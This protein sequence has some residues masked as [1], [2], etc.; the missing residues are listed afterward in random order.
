M[1]QLEQ[2]PSRDGLA[3]WS[4][5]PACGRIELPIR[6]IHLWVEDHGQS[7][8]TFICPS[9]DGLVRK[10][11]DAG[12]VGLLLASSPPLER[13]DL[14]DFKQELDRDDW[15]HRFERRFGS[16]LRVT[17]ITSNRRSEH[18]WLR[19]MNFLKQVGQRH[20]LLSS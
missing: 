1:G 15:F 9:C 10:H 11:A 12:T 2:T 6:N 7:S 17:R 16:A 3:I 8:Y 4:H 18:R 14:H 13:E 19:A 20:R 5:C